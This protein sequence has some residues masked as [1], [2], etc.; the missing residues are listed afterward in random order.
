MK[1]KS[2]AVFG[3]V[4]IGCLFALA[5]SVGCGTSQ[6]SSEAINM[7]VTW[8]LMHLAQ[9]IKETYPQ[10]SGVPFQAAVSQ[11]KMEDLKK[12][13]CNAAL[14]GREPT[15]EESSQF[16]ITAVARDAVC[17]VIDHNSY[18]GG[19]WAVG[20]MPVS[21][22]EGLR[23]L[24]QEDVRGIF[25]YFLN[26]ETGDYW[27]W[28]GEYYVWGPVYDPETGE[29]LGD[30]NSPLTHFELRDWNREARV[31]SCAFQFPVGKYD[32]QT[33][34]YQSLGLNEGE[35]AEKW[36]TYTSGTLN[37]EEEVVSFEY[38]NEMPFVAG[39]QDFRFKIGFV[40]RRVYELARENGL[41]I[42]A[43]SIDGINPA[44]DT[45]AVRN[46]DYPFVKNIYLVLPKAPSPTGEAL[47]GFLLSEEGQ[48]LLT[49]SGYLSVAG[50]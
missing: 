45:E 21:K 30:P 10:D 7:H 32:T 15:P 42:R 5:L 25:S 13:I 47:A 43:I 9:A 27:K 41:P 28:Q 19:E 20:S 22:T 37:T 16:S 2:S 11:S 26:L 39:S 14:L 17:I 23:N 18:E 1:R 34:L 44:W 36:H 8:D 49:E 3:A 50:N 40:T 48:Q 4:L 38:P 12:D 6:A 29:P 33:V 24:S 35:I 31:M 46:G